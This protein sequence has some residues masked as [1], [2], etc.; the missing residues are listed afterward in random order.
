MLEILVEKI[1]IYGEAKLALSPEDI[2]YYRNVL[3]F[4]FGLKKPYKGV[5]NVSEINSLT[6]P[7]ALIS[8]LET[9]LKNE[10][11]PHLSIQ[12]PEAIITDILGM[13]TPI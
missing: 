5:I 2:N 6:N 1:L 11:L 10:S 8:E 12:D 4:K 7:S 3:L 9:A 13:M